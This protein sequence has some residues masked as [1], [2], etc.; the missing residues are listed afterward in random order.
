MDRQI[1]QVVTE[2]IK[3]ME[4]I[5]KG[6]WKDRVIK[7]QGKKFQMFCRFMNI[8]YGKIIDYKIHIIEMK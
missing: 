5:I 4:M 3:L 8:P 2:Y 7:R 1:K 6:Q